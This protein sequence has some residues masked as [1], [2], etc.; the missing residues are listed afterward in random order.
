MYLS[1][2]SFFSKGGN[3]EGEL[4]KKEEESGGIKKS[5]IISATI[6]FLIAMAIVGGVIFILKNTDQQ[7][8]DSSSP[9]QGLT[10]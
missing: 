4:E 6:G 3:V 5:Y 8:Q 2:K 9:E 1:V 7:N 10:L